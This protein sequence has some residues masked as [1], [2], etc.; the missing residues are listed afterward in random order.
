MGRV[1]YR[2]IGGKVLAAVVAFAHCNTTVD[3]S[4]QTEIDCWGPEG[5]LLLLFHTL[6]GILSDWEDGAVA[7]KGMK[8]AGVALCD[9]RLWIDSCQNTV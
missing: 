8:L 6:H 3:G 1:D 7:D 9:P 2:D 4:D 5:S